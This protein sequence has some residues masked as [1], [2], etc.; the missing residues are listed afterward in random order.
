VYTQ[1]VWRPTELG[2]VIAERELTLEVEGKRR[3]VVVRF[4]KPVFPPEPESGDPWWCPMQIEGLGPDKVTPFGGLDSLQAL[5]LAVRF[6][7]DFLPAE[8]ARI[9]ARVY[10]T[11]EAL[12]AIFDQQAAIE[13]YRDMAEETLGALEAVEP[14][15]D[16]HSWPQDTIDFVTTVISK[17]AAET[18]SGSVK[19]E[20]SVFE[21][22]KT[23]Y[24]R[25]RDKF[26]DSS[27]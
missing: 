5:L 11:S 22:A 17:Y 27:A 4:G 1:F 16:L 12:D 14:L 8:A 23:L 20:R 3:T 19:Y 7:R 25:F 2:E 26:D 13:T 15:I 24:F 21:R 6:V 10:W 9:G 18:K